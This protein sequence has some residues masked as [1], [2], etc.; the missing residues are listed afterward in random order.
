MQALSLQTNRRKL[1]DCL[2]NKT[3]TISALPASGIQA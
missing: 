2:I 3:G 1:F